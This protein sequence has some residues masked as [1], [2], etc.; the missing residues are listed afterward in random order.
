M[1]WKADTEAYLCFYSSCPTPIF[2]RLENVFY[3]SEAVL[4]FLPE[5]RIKLI[6]NQFD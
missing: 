6:S 2:Y 4:L 5:S 1:P 3:T